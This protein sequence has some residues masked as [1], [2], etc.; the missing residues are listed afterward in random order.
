M[1]LTIEGLH[2]TPMK[3]LDMCLFQIGF[4]KLGNNEYDDME[5]L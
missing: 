4:D 2:Y 5:D 1:K 3:L